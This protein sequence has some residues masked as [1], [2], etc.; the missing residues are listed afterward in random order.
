MGSAR[1]RGHPAVATRAHRVRPAGRRPPGRR[2]RGGHRPPGHRVG[3][4][5][6]PGIARAPRPHHPHPGRHRRRPRARRGPGRPHRVRSD[7]ERSDMAIVVLVLWAFTAGAGFYLLISGNLGRPIPAAPAPAPLPIGYVPPRATT[8][9]APA[10]ASAASVTTPVRPSPPP[11][12]QPSRSP[13]PPPRPA[14]PRPR[15]A[16]PGPLPRRRSPGT[17]GPRPPW[18]LPGRRRILPG[19]RA[20]AEFAHPAV[21][22]IGLGFWLGFTLIH[23]RVLG[24]IGF[25]LAAATACAGL[26]WFTANNRAARQLAEAESGT[27]PSFARPLRRAARQRRRPHH[28]AGRPDRPAPAP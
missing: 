21:G 26:A 1:R 12:R 20:L 2:P 4:G 15:A 8:P 28:R 3:T 19:A 24:W 25:G 14:P 11:L 13:H 7:P 27:A 10:A 16:S 22:I 17:R 9:A 5:S 6:R 23:A 18:P